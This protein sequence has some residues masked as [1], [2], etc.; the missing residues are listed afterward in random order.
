MSQLTDQEKREFFYSIFDYERDGKKVAYRESLKEKAEKWFESLG[1]AKIV[2]IGILLVAIAIILLVVHPFVLPKHLAENI[3]GV[4]L[5]F[6]SIFILILITCSPLILFFV[7]IC[8]LNDDTKPIRKSAITLRQA[9]GQKAYEYINDKNSRLSD[10]LFFLTMLNVQDP[11][12]KKIT[13]DQRFKNYTDKLKI[14]DQ[15]DNKELSQENQNK[16]NQTITDFD[17]YLDKYQNEI[18]KLYIDPILD[19]T[20]INIIN[21]PKRKYYS[22]LP[23]RIKAKIDNQLIS[24]L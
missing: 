9:L 5:I 10:D 4:I 21:D 2:P 3:T 18:E 17:E 14:F 8:I 19:R 11:I 1:L 7:V 20:L 24:N 22:I 23:K 16:I 12:I 15:V 13:H 6:I